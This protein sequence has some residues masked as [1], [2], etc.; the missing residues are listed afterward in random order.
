MQELPPNLRM[1]LGL[2]SPCFNPILVTDN[3]VQQA[4][5]FRPSS[6][7]SGSSCTNIPR[8]KQLLSNYCKFSMLN[9]FAE[10]HCLLA[11]HKIIFQY[12][13]VKIWQFKF[14]R[15]LLALL[16]ICW[17]VAQLDGDWWKIAKS[18][19]IDSLKVNPRL[20][21][22]LINKDLPCGVQLLFANLL[23]IKCSKVF[24]DL[25]SYDLRLCFTIL[26]NAPD[27]N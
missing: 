24:H 18:K 26:S 22:K 3:N 1:F 14:A 4:L 21:N 23:L 20:T 7:G 11:V 16:P 5:K 15:L 12:S 19:L 9:C 10:K 27:L 13:E 8:C 17:T 25:S 2:L 6:N